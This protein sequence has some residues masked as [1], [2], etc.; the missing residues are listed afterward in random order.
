[1]TLPVFA[2]ERDAADW[3]VARLQPH[4]STLGREVYLRHPLKSELLR[5]DLL[6]EI[7]QFRPGWTR[8]ALVGVELKKPGDG[9]FKEWTAAV[10]QAH[11]YLV[12]G[13]VKPFGGHS[14]MDR[15]MW[16]FC[17]PDLRDTTVDASGYQ[18]WMEGAERLA[19][20]L[21]VGSLRTVGDG[22]LFTMSAAPMWSTWAGPRG[23]VDQSTRLQLG[24]R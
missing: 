21:N 15:P 23:A 8:P 9:G 24:A 5:I 7:E 16:V 17:W 2:C 10:A 19:G 6:L 14:P 11:S 13:L 22:F 4:V 20:R 12:A 3:L 18:G 1:M